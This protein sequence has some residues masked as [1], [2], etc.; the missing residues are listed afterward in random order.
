MKTNHQQIKE[1]SKSQM[2]AHNLEN[3]KLVLLA[4]SGTALLCALLLGFG[5]LLPCIICTGFR[6]K[7]TISYL[8]GMIAFLLPYPVISACVFSLA[9]RDCG[10]YRCKKCGHIHTPDLTSKAPFIIFTHKHTYLR[11]PHCRKRSFQKKVY[12]QD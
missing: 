2:S 3:T 7:A 4:V 5:S 9:D 6:D 11:C 10:A 8:V 1:T 12:Q